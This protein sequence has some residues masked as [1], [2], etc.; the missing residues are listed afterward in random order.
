MARTR[1]DGGVAQRVGEPTRRVQHDA[2][3]C[4]EKGAVST[5]G[6]RRSA[7]GHR[8]RPAAGAALQSQS[9]HAHAC[10]G[11]SNRVDGVMCGSS[12]NDTV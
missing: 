4:V 7:C 10:T 11:P 2:V 5:K 12:F 8:V 9:V 3:G 6:S 1:A